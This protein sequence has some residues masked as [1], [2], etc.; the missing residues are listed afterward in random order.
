MIVKVK[1]LLLLFLLMMIEMIGIF[2]LDIFNKFCVM[3]FFFLFFGIN[4]II[5]ISSVYKGNDWVVKFFCLF[6]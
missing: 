5:G 3:V 1:V 6:Y 2:K 4:F